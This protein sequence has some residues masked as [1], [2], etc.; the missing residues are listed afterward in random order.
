MLQQAVQTGK[1][2]GWHLAFLTDRILMNQGKKQ[3]Y[4]TQK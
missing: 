2:N 1:A 3:I 4:G